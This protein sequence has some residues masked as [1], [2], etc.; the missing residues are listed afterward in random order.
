[1]RALVAHGR[2]H[3][4]LAPRRFR[5]MAMGA[6][7]GSI[8]GHVVE[9]ELLGPGRFRLIDIAAAIDAGT[10][11]DQFAVE[12]QL[13]GG[14]VFG[15]NAALQNAVRLEAGGVTQ[16]NFHDYPMLRLADL[17]PL[18]TKIVASRAVLGGVGEEGVPTIAPAVANAL[19]AATGQPITRLP[20]ALA[21]WTLEN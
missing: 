15:L 19:L 21:G 18:R 9:V 14:T 11:I 10:V 1:M 5:G 6:A 13:M 17:P 4:P 3:E 12:A 20:L 16:S 8:S 7:N 2:W